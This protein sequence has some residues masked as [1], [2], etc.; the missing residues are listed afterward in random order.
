M[1]KPGTM[2]TSEIS[3]K[4]IYQEAHMNILVDLIMIVILFSVAIIMLG[5]GGI[6]THLIAMIVIAMIVFIMYFGI[7][8]RLDAIIKKDK[9]K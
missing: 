7:I 1:Q 2:K 3:I 4:K 8:S 9:E 6:N 5:M